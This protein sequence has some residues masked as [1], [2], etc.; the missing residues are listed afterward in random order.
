MRISDWS[1]DV[2]SSDLLVSNSYAAFANLNLE[3][4]EG[5]HLEAGGRVSKERR[6]IDRVVTPIGGGAVLIEGKE[7]FT[8]SQFTYKNG[9]D[10]AFKP[11]LMVY[12]SHSTGYRTG[13]FACPYAPPRDRQRGVSGRGVSI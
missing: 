9:I 8:E 7:A 3:P 6:V 11:T 12:D 4:I 2:C 13:S 1:S 5:L 10:Y